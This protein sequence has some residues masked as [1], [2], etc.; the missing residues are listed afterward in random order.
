MNRLE[1]KT[2]AT[3]EDGVFSVLLWE[4]KPFAVSVERSYGKAAKIQ[5]GEFWCLR[6]FYHKGGYETFQIQLPGHTR[7]LFHKGNTEDDVEGCV[8]VAESF[9]ELKG[10]TSVADSAG[11]F[12]EFMSLTGGLQA[13]KML[14]SGR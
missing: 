4:G 14:V 5:N 12:K 13:F 3:R 7:I 10:K 1:L 6:D 9:S 8:A 11:G 2:V